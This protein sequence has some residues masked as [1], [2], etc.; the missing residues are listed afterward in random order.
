[1][2]DY[3]S[4]YLSAV[5]DHRDM[6]LFKD[7]FVFK[8]L[9]FT[10]FPCQK[11]KTIL[12]LSLQSSVHKLVW[13]FLFDFKVELVWALGKRLTHCSCTLTHV[14]RHPKVPLQR[15][16]SVWQVCGP[17]YMCHVCHCGSVS[18]MSCHHI[19][20]CDV[21]FWGRWFASS[22]LNPCFALNFETQYNMTTHY[23][24]LCLFTVCPYSV[25][26]A[27]ITWKYLTMLVKNNFCVKILLYTKIWA[28]MAAL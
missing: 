20:W 15:Q 25:N 10:F 24:M 22:D 9:Y 21:D 28:R 18:W 16:Q 19:W 14:C 13:Q 1:M 26:A 6:N 3:L 17:L 5:R 7:F 2:S 8:C 23:E 4:I 27:E 11:K 12:S